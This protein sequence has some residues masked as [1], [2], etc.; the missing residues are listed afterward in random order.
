MKGRRLDVPVSLL[1]IRVLPAA[2]AQTVRL[3]TNEVKKCDAWTKCV[4]ST[5]RL[6]E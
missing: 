6:Q 3:G 1:A 4:V 5:P 2:D